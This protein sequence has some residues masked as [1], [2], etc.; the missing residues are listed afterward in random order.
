MLIVL[1]V[2]DQLDFYG[3]LDRQVSWSFTLQNA[4][5]ITPPSCGVDPQG[6]PHS[7]SGRMPQETHES[8]KSL[9]SANVPAVPATNESFLRLIS[10][11]PPPQRSWEGE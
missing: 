2:D 6:L 10:V 5:N 8:Q 4:A 11:L 3:L 9:A 1:A 7:S